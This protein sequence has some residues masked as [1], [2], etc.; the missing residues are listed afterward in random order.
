MKQNYTIIAICITI[1]SGCPQKASDKIDFGTIE[2]STYQNSYFGLSIK[3]PSDWNVQDQ[4]A[5]Q[6]LMEL[7]TNIVAGDDKNLKA[8]VKASELQTVNLFAAFKYPVGKPVDFNPSILCIAEQVRHMPGIK[9]GKDYLLQGKKLLESSP[10]EISFAED[11]Y[12]EKLGEMDFDVM[13]SEIRL[14]GQIIKQAQYAAIDKGYAL[15]FA[16]SFTN[17]EEKTILNGILESAQFQQ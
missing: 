16:I 6:K 9:R 1:F 3:I 11:T 17:D 8:V 5:R 15:M 13:T 2:N 12:T 4:A 10:M 14:G 7:G